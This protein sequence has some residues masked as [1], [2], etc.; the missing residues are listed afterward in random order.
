L[1]TRL[2][3]FRAALSCLALSGRRHPRGAGWELARSSA[4]GI[5]VI[6]IRVKCARRTSFE[7]ARDDFIDGS[8]VAI[9]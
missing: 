9:L 1:G 7:R 6:H 5:Y 3:V 4:Q 8:I 2:G